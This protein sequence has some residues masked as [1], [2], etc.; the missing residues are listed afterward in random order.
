MNWRILGISSCCPTWEKSYHPISTS[1]LCLCKGEEFTINN[2]QNATQKSIGGLT[3]EE[4]NAAKQKIMIIV[5][6][7]MFHNEADKHLA[8]LCAFKDSKGLIRLKTK[9][10]LRDD[11]EDFRSYFVLS[12][13]HPLIA[14][15]IHKLLWI[16]CHSG[17]C[18]DQHPSREVLDPAR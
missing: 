15:L 7:D 10:V 4:V 16:N 13:N 11:A 6:R 12:A 9:I 18:A 5:Q 14:R 17:V 8:P 2:T 1:I 3:M